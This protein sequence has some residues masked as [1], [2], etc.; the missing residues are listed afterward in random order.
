MRTETRQDFERAISETKSMMAAARAL[1]MSYD[2]FRKK[3]QHYGLFNPN[4]AGKGIK[5]AKKFKNREDVFKVFDYNVSRF[6]IKNW[7]LL[8]NKYE[9]ESCRISEWNGEHLTL[10]LEHINGNRRDNRI[11][12]LSLLCPNC[13]SQTKTWRRKK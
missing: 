2:T 8:E 12:N 9:C 7:Y 3:A 1:A 11:E 5:K 10:E 4:E 13:H 6:T